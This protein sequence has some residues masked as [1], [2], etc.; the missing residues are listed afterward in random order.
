MFFSGIVVDFFASNIGQNKKTPATILFNIPQQRA[1]A[2]LIKFAEQ[3]D[4]T[5]IIPFDALKG[6]M[7]KKLVG[8]YSIV[9]GVNLLL[10]NS[11]LQASMSESGQLSFV[12]QEPLEGRENMHKK[13]KLSI[14]ILAA[15]SSFFSGG[16]AAEQSNQDGEKIS[17]EIVVRGIKGSLQRALATKE[18]ASG[19]VDAISAED[20][21]KLPDNNVAEA[22]QRVAGVA[23]ERSRGEGDFIS[24]RGLGADFVKGTVN[25]RTLLS[26]TESIDPIFNGLSTTSAGRATNFDI[27]PSELVTGLEVSKSVSASQL[28]G[29]IAGSVEAKTARPLDLGNKSSFSITGTD[30]E[31]NSQFDPNVSG[32]LSWTNG[33][34]VGVLTSVSYSK[35]S[36]REDFSRQLLVAAGVHFWHRSCFGY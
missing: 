16:V 33:E 7:S 8:R 28:E 15:L 1:D 21:G 17:E 36:I 19:F 6:K 25:G 12:S 14:G 35:R 13:S 3:A 31:F 20:V 32:L 29:G 18:N 2:A 23:I 22:L 27:L 24:I 26:S 5:L 4:L 9:E 10:S 30:R 11:G 34:N